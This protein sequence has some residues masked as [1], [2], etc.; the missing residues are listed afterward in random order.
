MKLIP[1]I[2][3]LACAHASAQTSDFNLNDGRIRFSVPQSWGAIMEKS[4]GN[5]QAIAFAVADP[6]TAG[7]DDAARVTVKTRQLKAPSEYA[8]AMQN[9]MLLSKAQTGYAAEVE[10]KESGTHNYTVTRGATTYSIKDQFKLIGNF[11]VKVRCERPVLKATSK[12]WSADF[13]RDCAAVSA[14]IR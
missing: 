9:E 13:E 6:A 14:S 1:L 12:A 4:D 7:T 2:F 5:P 8:D 3:L 11:A 10:S